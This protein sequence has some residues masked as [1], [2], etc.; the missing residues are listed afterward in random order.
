MNQCP[1][2][3][4]NTIRQVGQSID[5]SNPN[6]PAHTITLGRQEFMN[7]T[8][9]DFASYKAGR[10]NRVLIQ[11]DIEQTEFEENLAR[12]ERDAKI[13]ETLRNVRVIKEPTFG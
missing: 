10:D 11:M 13:R 5:C 4:Q 8:A 2:C 6:C 12:V 3:Q 7:L 9:A 1:H